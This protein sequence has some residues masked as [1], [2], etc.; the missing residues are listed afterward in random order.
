MT[1]QLEATDSLFKINE[2]SG[3]LEIAHPGLDYETQNSHVFKVIARDSGIPR[4][5]AHTTVNVT[6]VD[7]NDNR[8]T[9]KL[10]APPGGVIDPAACLS[11]GVNCTFYVR[12]S[13]TVP[14]EKGIVRLSADDADGDGNGSPFSFRIK[15]GN[16]AGK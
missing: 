4:L 10:K 2:D 5:S 1:Y 9:F 14:V 13:E 6:V 16:D 12:E 11:N 3:K 15:D 7:V 8:P